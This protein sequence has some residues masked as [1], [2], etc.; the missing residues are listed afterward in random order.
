M[1]DLISTIKIFL[2]RY[3]DYDKWTKIS[4]T[5]ELLKQIPWDTIYDG[6]PSFIHGDL[7]FDNV[8]YNHQTDSFVLLDWRQDFGGVV[9]YGDMYYDIAKMRGNY[10]QL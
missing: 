9:E 8:L 4:K 1:K 6:I 2:L 5:S 7:Q 3:R 10:S